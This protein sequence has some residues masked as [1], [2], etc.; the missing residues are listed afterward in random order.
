LRVEIDL[1]LPDDQKLT[2]THG[3]MVGRLSTAAVHLADPRISEAHALF[4]L[5]G[6]VLRFLALR[7]RFAVDG[8][9]SV[10]TVVAEGM[11]LH[12]AE[13][14]TLRVLEIRLPDHLLGLEIEA[15]GRVVPEGNTSLFGGARPRV[16]TGWQPDAAGWIW[17]VPS[18]WMR[19]GDPAC[20]IQF[21]DT[22]HVGRTRVQAVRI[23]PQGLDDTAAGTGFGSPLVLELYYDTVHIKRVDH[24]VLVVRG[25]SARILS[26]VALA[27]APLPWLDLARD[28]WGDESP[29]V[30]RRRWDTQMYR[31]RRLF[32]RHGVAPGLLRADGT[33]LVELVLRTADTLVDRT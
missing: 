4:S 27:E 10:D 24:E 29:L 33:G 32:R 7:G 23:A 2:V 18:G 15:L 14:M 19:S 11:T 31:L 5:R 16:A 28:T 1:L 20:A 12:L 13:G 25:T 21:D 6:R 17:P 26:D 3:A 22:W 8:K 30:L 9:T